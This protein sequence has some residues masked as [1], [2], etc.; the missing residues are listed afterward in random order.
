MRIRS[1]QLSANLSKQLLPAYLVT[2]DELL[3]SQE[4]CDAIRRQSRE[5][6]ISE[7][8]VL[9]VDRSFDWAQLLD[10]GQ[11]MS[12]FGDRKLIELRLGSGKMDQKSSAALQEYLQHADGSNILLVSCAKLDSRSM[13]SKWVKA[14]DSAG[15][16]IQV[17][18][19]DRQHLNNWI[20]QRMRMIG[21]NAD[22]DAVQLLAD[23]V[24]GNLLA[25]D[26]EIS[27]LK[28]LVGEQ[29]VSADIV[30]NAVASSA[31][32]DVFKLIDSALA[33]KTGNALQM[34]NSLLAEG[35]EDI[36]MLGAV[37][38]EI[39]TLYQCAQQLEQGGSID[40]VLDSARVWDK[41]KALYKNT[42]RRLK[43]SQL[44]KLLQL[45]SKID[46]AQKGQSKENSVVLF[47]NLV[48][49]LSGQNLTGLR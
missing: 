37:T 36:A 5:Q 17:W 1:E 15:A 24:E 20:M 2:G 7:R 8:E 41:R 9:N 43:S 16:V 45:A 28:I 46:A 42:L 25:A 34:L 39:R 22:N 30:A 49:L 26:Q 44:A 14:L 21:L 11:S 19:V 18:P 12:L 6:G 3:I 33:G 10:A 4:C 38:R 40:R 23:R 31:R 47:T 35:G 29:T 48:S 32:Y 27:K 13:N